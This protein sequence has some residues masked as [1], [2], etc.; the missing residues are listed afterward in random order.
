[1]RTIEQNFNSWG[2][3]W[4]QRARWAEGLGIPMM[5]EANATQGIEVLYWV[6]CA[7]WFDDRNRKVAQAFSRI[8]R[9]AGVRFAILG[10]AEKVMGDPPRRL[11]ND[12]LP[13]PM[14]V[15]SLEPL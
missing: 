12:Y 7:A 15:G 6:G 11:G 3:G 5:A 8:L 9:K 2:I 14:A 10:P 4:D 13:Q 1:M